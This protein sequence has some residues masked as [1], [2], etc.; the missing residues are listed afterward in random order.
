M[1][2]NKAIAFLKLV[3][4]ENLLMIVFTQ[5]LL[6]YVVLQKIVRDYGLQLEL[7]DTL[8]ALVIIST[9]LIAAA[10]YIIND[11][12]DVKTDLINHPDT[13]VVDR[14][15][16]RRWAIIL[17]ISFT[18]LGLVLGVYAALKTG[19]LRLAVFHVVAAVLLWFY[20]THFKKMLLVGNVVVSLLT[21]AVAFMPFVY[22]MGVM[23]KT[24][25]GFILDYTAL[26]WVA[27]KTTALFSVF[28]FLTSMAR[29]I[30]KDVED[31]KGDAAT[32]GSTLPI[33][34][35]IRTAKLVVFFVLVIT[36]LLLFFVL[37]N[38]VKSQMVL[39]TLNNLYLLLALM[40]PLLLLS[41]YLAKASESR[42]FKRA[43]L[44]L[45][46]IMLLGLSYSFIFYYS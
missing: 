33:A 18:F 42:E 8:F 3:R 6:R 37:Y 20:S 29:E 34:W 30:I 5:W 16:K 13:V 11:Y 27:F 41:G 4:F 7:G 1:L 36:F 2:N 12:F 24:H 35:G 43:S 9:V 10:G 38:T 28:A 15:I 45:K 31:Y 44:F 46:L 19:Y 40:L 21:A 32:G 22:E 39:F 17:H 23:Q 26:T 14:V 25:P